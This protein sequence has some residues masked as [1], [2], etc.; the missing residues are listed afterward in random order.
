[1]TAGPRRAAL[2]PAE[3]PG[4]RAELAACCSAVYGSPLAEMLVGPS[5]HPGGLESTRAL[6]RAAALPRGA[7]LLDAGCGLGASA[8]V[9]EDEFGLRVEAV[10]AS[11]AVVARAEARDPGDVAW[12]QGDLLALPSDDGTFDGVLAECVLST[13]PREAALAEIRRVTHR[14]GVLAL[15]DVATSGPAPTAIAGG[16]LG[17][18]LCVGDAW[19]P[20]ELE[21][22]LEA[23][24][25]ALERRWDRSE[26]VIELVDRIEAR[27]RVALAVA[28]DSA[29][30]LTGLAALA[31]PGPVLAGGPES[32]RRLAEDVRDAVR[33]GELG[34]FAAIARAR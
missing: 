32:A 4:D 15:S 33:G 5:L 1:M 7:T 18:A 28:R 22:R 24:G 27:L 21:A 2:A 8:H 20:D 6:L 31:G 3:L 23:G 11:A 16:L 10:D 14:G 9:A 26:S 19:R 12:R 13:V 17:V 25:F 34:Y 30:D 29:L